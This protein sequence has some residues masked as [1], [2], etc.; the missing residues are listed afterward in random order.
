MWTK[1]FCFCTYQEIKRK[2]WQLKLKTIPLLPLL[3]VFTTWGNYRDHLNNNDDLDHFM[4]SWKRLIRTSHNHKL[5]QTWSRP[6]QYSVNMAKGSEESNRAQ[7]IKIVWKLTRRRL[8]CQLQTLYL[9]N[10]RVSKTVII[11]LKCDH[12][13]PVTVQ[14]QTQCDGISVISDA[15]P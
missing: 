8:G 1:S 10:Y 11:L 5:Y 15:S 3:F 6:D 13:W 9:G 7:S 2:C 4:A 14:T 12:S